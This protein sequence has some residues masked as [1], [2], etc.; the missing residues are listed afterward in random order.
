MSHVF[1]GI[2]VRSRQAIEVRL[3]MYSGTSTLIPLPAVHFLSSQVLWC[4]HISIGVL[5]ERDTRSADDVQGYLERA[6][7]NISTHGGIGR[8]T[9]LNE[10]LVK[11]M[12]VL[13]RS[14]LIPRT[15]VREGSTPSGCT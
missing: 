15:K 9:G 3:Q 4:K 5:I 11:I 6:L 14:W 1:G 12:K 2:A 8:R 13:S 10:S 7:R